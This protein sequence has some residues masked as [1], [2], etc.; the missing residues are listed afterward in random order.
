MN[1]DFHDNLSGGPQMPAGAQ[2]EPAGRPRRKWALRSAF[3][4]LFVALG[5]AAFG[6]STASAQT[7]DEPTSAEVNPAMQIQPAV[8]ADAVDDADT[9]DSEDREDRQALREQRRAEREAHRAEKLAA[10]AEL[11]GTD[12]EA[13]EAAKEEGKSLADV[14]AENSVDVQTVI[15]AIVT[16]IQGRATEAG[17][18]LTDEQLAEITDKVTAR[19]NGEVPEGHE[20]R[21]GHRHGKGHGHRGFGGGHHGGADDGSVEEQNV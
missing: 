12:S 4:A 15:D 11:L 8:A 17:K 2:G 5:L 1:T 14:A 10:L 6:V 3:V 21:R 19:V 9:E 18:E 13:L 20:G 16:D 7:T